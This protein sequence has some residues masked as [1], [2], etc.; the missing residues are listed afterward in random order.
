MAKRS[1][2]LPAEVQARVNDALR[3]RLDGAE[4]W[5]LREF[6]REEAGS[7]WHLEPGENPL[8]DSQIRRYQQ[9][10]DAAIDASGE[11][12]RK[13]LLRRH[14]A[15]RRN[16]YAKAV[17]AG[18]HRTALACLSDEAKLLGL[19][20]AERA[21]HEHSGP[22]GTPIE[23]KVSHDVADLLPSAD[24]VGALLRSAFDAEADRQVRR[25]GAA[26]P[27]DTARPQ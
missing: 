6:V 20:P 2:A 25:D 23:A 4:F 22:K 19:Y 1:R 17:L 7:A 8:S 15:K 16:L 3:I 18:D 13:K 12:S 14:A 9:W 5:D 10:A 24:V 26:E 21:K 11:R 27:L